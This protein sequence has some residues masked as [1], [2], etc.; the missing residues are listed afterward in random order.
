MYKTLINNCVGGWRGLAENTGT[1]GGEGSVLVTDL[2]L[3]RSCI[4]LVKLHSAVPL[5][6]AHFSAVMLCSVK[7]L[8]LKANE[9]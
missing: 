3:V 2:A 4:H 8:V 5:S 6:F 9:Q 1:P 7:T